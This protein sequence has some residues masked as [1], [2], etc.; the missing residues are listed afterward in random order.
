MAQNK[1][2]TPG[3]QCIVQSPWK[4]N[5]LGIDFRLCGAASSNK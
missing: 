1:G 4:K 2:V 3:S 5:P